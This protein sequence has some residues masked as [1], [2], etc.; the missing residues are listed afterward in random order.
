MASPHVAGVAALIRE[1]HPGEA[2][3]RSRPPFGGVAPMACATDWHEA[4]P[5]RR[6]GGASKTSFYGAGMANALQAVAR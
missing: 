1:L 6:T 2:R 4:D 5:R 3:P